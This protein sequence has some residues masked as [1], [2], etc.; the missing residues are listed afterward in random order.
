VRAEPV[1]L[2]I[3]IG[4]GYVAVPWYTVSINGVFLPQLLSSPTQQPGVAVIGPDNRILKGETGDVQRYESL[5]DAIA[6]VEV[7]RR[8]NAD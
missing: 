2:C 1:P 6:D 8:L 5:E 7:L 4:G 3:G